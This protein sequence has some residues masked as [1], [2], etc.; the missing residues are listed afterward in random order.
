MTTASAA[1]LGPSCGLLKGTDDTSTL[2]VKEKVICLKHNHNL[3]IFLLRVVVFGFCLLGILFAFAL[4]SIVLRVWQFPYKRFRSNFSCLQIKVYIYSDASWELCCCG[5]GLFRE[6]V[7]LTQMSQSEPCYCW[8]VIRE[9]II[10]AAS[11]LN[12]SVSGL[13][14]TTN[15][16]GNMSI[17]L[18]SKVIL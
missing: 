10:G 9:S 14:L 17:P 11:Y 6:V 7:L 2:G 1:W 8:V 13:L 16:E 12:L 18:L 4:S 5:V 3:Y 15:L